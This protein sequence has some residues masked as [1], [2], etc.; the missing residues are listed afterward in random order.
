M[1]QAVLAT[2]I[3]TGRNPSARKMEHLEGKNDAKAVKTAA[4]CGM[5]AP[6][7]F[8]SAIIIA[9]AMRPGYDHMTEYIS[10]LGGSGDASSYVM[11][12]AG[13]FLYGLLL[14]AFGYGL[15]KRIDFKPISEMKSYI[16]TLKLLTPVLAVLGA[17]GYLA[18][19]FWTSDMEVLH[20]AAGA[21]AILFWTLPILTIFVF[22]SEERWRS[23]WRISLGAFITQAIIGLTFKLIITDQIGL[24][25]RA[26]YVPI[27]VW[28]ELVAIKMYKLA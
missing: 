18:A 10:W 6:I 11:N 13:F 3:A 4:I 5:V 27:L 25:Q 20:G 17:I 7:T 15:F 9:G 23:Y 1:I 2:L 21:F 22:R 16:D 8:T 26:G 24:G 28:L 12:F 19:A 14:L